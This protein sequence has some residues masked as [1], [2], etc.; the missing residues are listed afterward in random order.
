[1]TSADDPMSPSP[2]MDV[3]SQHNIA[4]SI[5]WVIL[6][7][8]AQKYDGAD[9]RRLPATEIVDNFKAMALT[10]F[11][12]IVNRWIASQPVF[13]VIADVSVKTSASVLKV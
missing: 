6:R 1:M 3:C 5:E 12:D 11:T 7:E 9:F 10:V 4:A 8:T 13:F 2:D